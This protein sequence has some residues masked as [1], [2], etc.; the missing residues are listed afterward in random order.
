LGNLE[1][2]YEF[3]RSN[4]GT[5]QAQ[6]I[7]LPL[8]TDKKGQKLG[9]STLAAQNTPSSPSNELTQ[10]S[11]IWL[12][13]QLTSPYAFYQYF[14]QLPDDVSE[15]LLPFF[16]LRPFEEV[17]DVLVEHRKNLGQWVAQKS[18]ADELTRLVHG[19]DGVETA[20]RC[21]RLLFDGS[22]EE[23]DEL[24]AE[25]V[26]ALFG[27]ASTYRVSHLGSSV[28]VGMERNIPLL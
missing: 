15:E 23:F 13:S 7:C 6:G 19:A 25:T 18:L 11:A 27:Q 22:L 16:S 2:G 5:H 28:R 4:H 24:S 26:R 17:V 20:R 12:D 3:I 9:K 10:G 14:R 1:A 8:L 21:S